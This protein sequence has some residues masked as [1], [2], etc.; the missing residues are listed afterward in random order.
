MPGRPRKPLK[1]RQQEGDRRKIGAKK[2]Q[3]LIDAEPRTQSGLPE[4]PEHLNGLARETW[5]RWSEQLSIMELD[6]R[7]D[8]EMLE[9]ACVAYARAV[10][11]DA[12]IQR[13][14]ITIKTYREI[15]GEAVLTGI[16]PHPAV[17]ISSEAWKQ[18]KSFCTEFGFSPASRA[19]LA[20]GK[21]QQ[22]PGDLM[23]LLMAD[24]PQKQAVQ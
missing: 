14:G 1:V 5:D 12:E 11:A 8:A 20:V 19:K 15:D 13:D 18:V 17:R 23:A 2:L 16:A 21:Q 10:R 3:A 9:G 22:K 24:E 4:C 6:R 7:P